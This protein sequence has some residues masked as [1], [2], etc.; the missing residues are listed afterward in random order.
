MTTATASL[1]RILSIPELGLLGEPYYLLNTEMPVYQNGTNQ[2]SPYPNYISEIKQ[3]LGLDSNY[4][5]LSFIVDKR[6][7]DQ[8]WHQRHPGHQPNATRNTPAGAYAFAIVHNGKAKGGKLNA[9]IEGFDFIRVKAAVSNANGKP[10]PFRG[11]NNYYYGYNNKEHNETSLFVNI[12]V[13]DQVIPFCISV[14]D[15]ENLLDLTVTDDLKMVIGKHEKD[16][17]FY[18]GY[19]FR[20]AAQY[21]KYYANG[22]HNEVSFDYTLNAVYTLCHEIGIHKRTNVASMLRGLM[23][24]QSVTPLAVEG[25][26]KNYKKMCEIIDPHKTSYMEE[27]ITFRTFAL[28]SKRSVDSVKISALF[29]DIF[30]QVEDLKGFI[31]AIKPLLTGKFHERSS[32]YYGYAPGEGTLLEKLTKLPCYTDRRRAI[33][34]SQGNRAFSKL[35]EEYDSLSID[36]KKFPRISKLIK[37]SKLPVGTFFRKKEQ[38]FLLNDNWHLWEEMLKRGFEE[39]CIKLAKEVS[40]RSTYEKD[41]MSYFYFILYALPEYLKKHTKEKWTCSPRLVQS[42]SELE[43]PADDGTGTRRERSALTPIV[44]NEKKTVVVPYASLALAGYGT[45]YCYSHNYT[46]LTKGFSFNGNVVMNDIEEKLN[47]RDDYGL[48]FYT[49]TGSHNARGYPTF[50]IIFERRSTGTHVH[51][52]RT[53]PSRSKDGDYNPIHN[54]VRVCYNWMAGN[55]RKE[56]IK[57]QQ[58]DLVFVEVPEDEA[59]LL[60]F[61][62]TVNSYDNHAFEKKVHFARYEKKERSNILGYVRLDEKNVLQHH[63]HEWVDMNPGTYQIRQ[64]RSWEANPQGVW[65]LRID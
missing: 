47:G 62:S 28:L 63:E 57:Y 31:K 43:P 52:H 55:V 24:S 5:I 12:K 17:G 26:S 11:N 20:E 53:H 34:K 40:S 2:P 39:E 3:A 41:L 36:E 25:I 23:A 18:K 54:W 7:H 10:N 48:M 46:V 64:C 9:E 50:L 37:E 65:S 33:L 13:L 42:E 8:Y 58:G 35:M 56:R 14:E 49:L 19:G 61:D 44:D 1:P 38:Y 16:R 29:N 4:T 45:T 27:F 22:Y 30:G 21:C 59:K 60:N 15:A 32:T 51:F 6:S